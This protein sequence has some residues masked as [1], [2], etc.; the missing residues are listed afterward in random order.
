MKE[1]IHADNKKEATQIANSINT[2]LIFD[3]VY[4]YNRGKGNNFYQFKLG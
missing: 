3:K 1:I 4:K 2:N